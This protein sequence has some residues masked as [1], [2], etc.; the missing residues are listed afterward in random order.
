M[1]SQEFGQTEEFEITDTLT[2]TLS[3]FCTPQTSIY[4]QC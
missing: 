3:I 4:E 2:L 1:N